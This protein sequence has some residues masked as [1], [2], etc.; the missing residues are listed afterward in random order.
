LFQVRAFGTLG[1]TDWSN[2]VRRMCIEFGNHMATGRVQH[3]EPPVAEWN[4]VSRII[5]LNNTDAFLEARPIGIVLRGGAPSSKGT[6]V[7][8]RC[9]NE[10]SAQYIHPKTTR[11]VRLVRADA[12]PHCICSRDI[13]FP[14]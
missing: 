6:T 3:V 13:K 2:P 11:Y 14:V 4:Y 12:H 7:Q 8:N 5:I 10:A 9:K 1:F